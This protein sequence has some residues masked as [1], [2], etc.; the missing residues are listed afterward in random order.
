MNQKQW[1]VNP[2]HFLRLSDHQKL[3]NF[4]SDEPFYNLLQVEQ[5][6]AE[7]KFMS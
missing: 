7:K 1:T 5:W 6:E 3:Q 4:I 2:Y